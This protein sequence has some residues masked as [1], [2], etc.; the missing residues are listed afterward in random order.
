MNMT[1]NS[2]FNKHP[3]P[4]M[5]KLKICTASASADVQNLTSDPSLVLTYLILLH[6]L[7]R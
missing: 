1:G 7:L 6:A 4:R 3:H 5:L 2:I